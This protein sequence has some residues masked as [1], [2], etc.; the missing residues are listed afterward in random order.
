MIQAKNE[1]IKNETIKLRITAIKD[2]GRKF[3][4]VFMG[5]KIAVA[6]SRDSGA[7]VGYNAIMINGNI[8]SGGSRAN[9]YCIVKKGST[10]EIEVDKEFYV[11]NKNRIKNWEMQ[12]IEENSLSKER[13]NAL[14][15]M[16]NNLE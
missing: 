6:F 13:S 7:R 14:E 5:V 11:K 2:N 9:W 4:V 16:E 10:F 8:D 3:A 1:T 12:E 15:K